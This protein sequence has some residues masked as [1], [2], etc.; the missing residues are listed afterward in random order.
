MIQDI[1]L[2]YSI[3]GRYMRIKKFWRLFFPAYSVYV[4]KQ[5]SAYTQYAD[6]KLSAYTLYADKVNHA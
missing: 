3:S 4:D 5:S 6:K 1:Y 2:G